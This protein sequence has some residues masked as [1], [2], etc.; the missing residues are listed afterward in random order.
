LIRL[1]QEAE[2]QVESL[3]DY[4][5]SRDRTEASRNLRD[6]LISASDRVLEAPSSGLAA[7][8]P[9]PTLVLPGHLWLKAGSYWIAYSPAPEPAIVAVFHESANIPGRL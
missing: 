1:T 9:Y 5:E 7:P 8:R 2:A 6:A 3:I 4:Y